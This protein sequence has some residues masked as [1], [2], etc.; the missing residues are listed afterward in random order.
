[1]LTEILK[2]YTSQDRGVAV[3]YTNWS[4]LFPFAHFGVSLLPIARMVSKKPGVWLY[5]DAE[6]FVNPFEFLIFLYK[7]DLKCDTFSTQVLKLDKK[8]P[9][10]QMGQGHYT[11]SWIY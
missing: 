1:M 7:H 5:S 2:I 10:K 3:H 4:D 11:C 8:N 6:K 9:I